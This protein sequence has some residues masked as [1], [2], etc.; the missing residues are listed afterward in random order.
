VQAWVRLVF[1]KIHLLLERVGCECLRV[2]GLRPLIG[3]AKLQEKVIE[4]ATHEPV[5]GLAQ[6]L[7]NIRRLLTIVDDHS[8]EQVVNPLV[9]SLVNEGHVVFIDRLN[10]H[11]YLLQN[12]LVQSLDEL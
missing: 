2:R 7:A 4:W 8:H 11:N 9:L 3:H 12:L 1:E 10:Q 6:Q 5:K